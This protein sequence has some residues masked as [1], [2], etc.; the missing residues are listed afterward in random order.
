MSEFKNPRVSEVPV[1]PMFIDRWSPRAFSPEP[2]PEESLRTMFEAA[3]WAPS[4]FG[5]EPW[6]FLYATKKK[7]LELFRSL[8]VDGNRTWADHAPVLAFVFARK[9]FARN[10]KPNRWAQFD[11]GAAWMSLALQAT[12]LGYYTH[13]M[14]G[15]HEEKVYEALNVP[16]DK[17]E[18]MAAIAIGS[19]GDAS[20]L[21]PQLAEKESPNSRKPLSEV[22]IEG[23][24]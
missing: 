16:K 9:T 13:G 10:D 23:K 8:L 21:P 18:A 1:D 7:D 19:R 15:F 2:V 17:Y 20:K 5:E 24:L 12:R 3:R 14:G 22:A 6:L 11:S 4:C